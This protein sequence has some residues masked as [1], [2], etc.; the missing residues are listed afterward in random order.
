MDREVVHERYEDDSAPDARRSRKERFLAVSGA[1]ANLETSSRVR[2]CC[3]LVRSWREDADHSLA[4]LGD[5]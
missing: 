3:P 2:V 1:D 4:G 5:E